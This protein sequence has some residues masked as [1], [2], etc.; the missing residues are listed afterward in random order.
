MQVEPGMPNPFNPR[1]TLAFTLV[2][3]GPT[4]VRV[5]DLAGRLIAT[6]LD[7]RMAA[8]RHTVEWDGRTNEGRAAPSGVYFL[9]VRSGQDLGSAKMMLVR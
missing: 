8:G 2:R 7:E 9:T 5:V 1:T 6:L 3:P 4:R